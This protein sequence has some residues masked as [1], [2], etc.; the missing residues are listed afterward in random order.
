MRNLGVPWQQKNRCVVLLFVL[1]IA[2]DLAA[3]GRHNTRMINNSMFMLVS[4]PLVEE[5][6]NG[7]MRRRHAME[8]LGKFR[9]PQCLTKPFEE[10]ISGC[11][12]VPRP[13]Q[14]SWSR[15]DA[16]ARSPPCQTRDPLKAEWCHK[17]PQQ[18]P[19]PGSRR[20]ENGLVC[21]TSGHAAQYGFVALHSAR[22]CV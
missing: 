12:S 9:T 19:G 10:A 22:E 5:A 14:W 2:D 1:S 17:G 18:T 13:N 15:G 8:F 20:E 16:W 7:R 6:R 11:L 4:E 3:P 21:S